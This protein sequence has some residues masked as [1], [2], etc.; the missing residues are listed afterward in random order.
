MAE[1][2]KDFESSPS[3]VNAEFGGSPPS[4]EVIFDNFQY[5]LDNLKAM[6]ESIEVPQG[7]SIKD[8]MAREE[9]HQIQLNIDEFQSK[10]HLMKGSVEGSMVW[11]PVQ[12][13]KNEEE[14]V[15][16]R[17]AEK[18]DCG[19]DGPSDKEED[20]YDINDDTESEASDFVITILE[21]PPF[22]KES[23]FDNPRW[24]DPPLPPS[25]AQYF[26]PTRSV[27][28]ERGLIARTSES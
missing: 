5:Q 9:L 3:N 19:E 12:V 17:E 24:S 21:P 25:F 27:G 13:S 6:F 8:F 15:I 4:I 26:D 10:L 2:R 28:P 18:R 7:D 11:D 20:L 16:I 23:I 1:E 14:E 22:F